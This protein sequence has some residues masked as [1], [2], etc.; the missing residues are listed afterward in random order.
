[1][2]LWKRAAGALKDKNSICCASLSGRGKYR[3]PDLEAVV[4]KATSH[5]ESR[6]DYK[7]F[8]RVFEW[9]RT[10]PIF[11]KSL[12]WALSIRMEK[13]KSWPVALKGLILIH[14]VFSYPIPCIQR[15]GRLP[16]DLS[17]FSD[18]HSRPEKIWGYNAFVRAYF[19]YLDQR[20]AF[21]S[22]ETKK[23]RKL[24]K[25]TE[26]TLMEE[27]EKVQKLQALIDMLIQIKPQSENMRVTVIL[28]AMDVVIVE[29]FDVYSRFCNGIA[30]I[31][32]RIY[33][34]R[35]KGGSKNGTK[36]SS[37]SINTRIPD[38]DIR[39]LEQ[40]INGA[41]RKR[42]LVDNCDDLIPHAEKAILVKET[43][44]IVEYKG[45]N[46]NL[47]TVITDKWEVFD[48]DLKIDNKVNFDDGSRIA[49]S[50]NPFVDSIFF[51]PHNPPAYNQVLPDLISL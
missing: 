26:E 48:E 29:L 8:N 51:I 16:F 49:A 23:Q 15:I 10:S 35:W 1:M 21:V 25:E 38:E 7:N 34:G 12:L 18:R 33:D 46:K 41:S 50:Q 4:I 36:S 3:N 14:G 44:D 22:S 28:E 24:S 37:E 19:A 43:G 20:S 32:M 30:R 11:L 5:D 2:R 42:K 45:S 9:I 6:L 47:K 13:T 39:E 40:I 27:L 31:L 17:N